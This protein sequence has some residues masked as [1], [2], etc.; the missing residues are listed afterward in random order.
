MQASQIPVKISTLWG[1]SAPAG[2]I[3]SPIPIPSQIGVTPGRASFTDGFPPVCFIPT[4]GG[5]TPPFGADFNGIFNMLSAWDRWTA[6]GGSF[7]TWDGT[8]STAIGG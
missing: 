3:T 8:F 7:V 1:A 4:T 2:N 6:A 5:G